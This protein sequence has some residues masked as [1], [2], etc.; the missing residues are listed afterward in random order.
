MKRWHPPVRA[1][2]CHRIPM[3][4]TAARRLMLAAWLPLLILSAF[5][6]GCSARKTRTDEAPDLEV[7][8]TIEP[9]PAQMGAA[10]LLIVLHSPNGTPITAA[11]IEVKGDMSHAGMTPVLGE[12][13]A[14]EPGLY[15]VPFEWT[16]A[17]EWHLTISGELADG[18]NLYRTF[19]VPVA[20]PANPP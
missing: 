12:A 15:Q 6:V 19:M 5:Q 11:Q 13:V 1:A 9:S 3:N 7:Q 14:V 16:M 17:G 8:L 2:R 20:M 10:E 4:T 18:R